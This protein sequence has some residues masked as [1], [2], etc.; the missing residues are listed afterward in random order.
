[1]EKIS[2]VD[3]VSTFLEENGYKKV[4]NEPKFVD[5]NDNSAS[6]LLGDYFI[7]FKPTYKHLQTE[8]THIQVMCKHARWDMCLSI[9]PSG[10]VVAN[11]NLFAMYSY[12][13]IGPPRVLDI[14]LADPKSFDLFKRLL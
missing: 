12:D 11:M 8:V 5:L 6:P 1:M 7:L 4:K 9:H 2:T 13:R 10:R 3:I 14:D